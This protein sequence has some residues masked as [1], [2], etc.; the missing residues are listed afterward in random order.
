[1]RKKNITLDEFSPEVAEL[2]EKESID[3]LGY[4]KLASI[5]AKEWKKLLNKRPEVRSE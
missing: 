3:T 5:P 4:D 2:F 1:L